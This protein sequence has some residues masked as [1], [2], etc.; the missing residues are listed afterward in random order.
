MGPTYFRSA[1][2]GRGF[3]GGGFRAAAIGP[4]FRS[5]GF[6]RGGFGTMPLNSDI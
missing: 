5:A 2:I 1:V 6:S 3:R 4:G